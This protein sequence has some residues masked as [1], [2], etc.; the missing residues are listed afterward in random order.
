MDTRLA[1]VQAS[2]S[3]F[4]NFGDFQTQKTKRFSVVGLLPDNGAKLVKCYLF[5]SGKNVK[6]KTSI[7]IQ[8]LLLLE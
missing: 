8:L 3:L 4:V 7:D 6:T 2:F 1:G 5:T